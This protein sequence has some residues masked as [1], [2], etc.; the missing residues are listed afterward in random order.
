MTPKRRGRPPLPPEAKPVAVSLKLPPWV[1]DHYCRLAMSS[2]E[3]VH[4][5]I[6]RAVVRD[7]SGSAKTR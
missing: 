6:R 5:L 4:G 7:I 1:Y 2:G 3:S